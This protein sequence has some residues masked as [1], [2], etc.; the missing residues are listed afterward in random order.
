MFPRNYFLPS[1]FIPSYFP[2]TGKSG[3][4]GKPGA[5]G[6][7]GD[8]KKRKQQ[9]QRI[10]ATMMIAEQRKTIFKEQEKLYAKMEL[11]KAKRERDYQHEAELIRQRQGRIMNCMTVLLAEI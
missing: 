7:G 3:G 9:M 1:F 6:V 10:L 5:G 2:K 8:D 11:A 4:K